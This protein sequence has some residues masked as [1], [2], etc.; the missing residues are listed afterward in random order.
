MEL[1]AA[2]IGTAISGDDTDDSFGSRGVIPLPNGNYLIGSHQDDIGGNSDAGSVTLVN[3]STGAVIA[4]IEGDMADDMLGESGIAAQS[5]SGFVI[6][7]KWADDGA[8]VN[9]GS[10][11]LFDSDGVTQIGTTRYG[12]NA[13]DQLGSNGVIVLPNDNYVISS[14]SYGTGD[15]GIIELI[16][17]SDGSFIRG[18]VG[19]DGEFYSN[20]D[21]VV[22]PNGNFAYASYFDNSSF[23]VN[24]AGTVL[25]LDG[26]DVV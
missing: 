10:V 1:L 7:S 16:D 5:T 23:D 4:T 13:E 20:G 19:D 26:T 12:S 3:G 21:L 17:G 14:P 25:I 18:R 8:T 6:A 2:Q 22:L 11:M 24:N 9:A 15:R